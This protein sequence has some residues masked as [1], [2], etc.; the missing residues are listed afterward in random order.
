MW[1]SP[2]YL[3]KYEYAKTNPFLIRFIAFLGVLS[4]I[5]VAIGFLNYL[6][7]NLLYALVF[8]PIIFIFVLNKFLR[9]FIQLFYQKFDPKLH[10]SF[11]KKYWNEHDEPAVD[12]FLPWAG[13]DLEMHEQVVR[14]VSWINYKNK[15]VY[16]LDDI[17]SEEHRLLAEKYGFI[18]LS[19]PNKGQHKKSGNLEYGYNHS[20]GDYVFILDADF[21]PT[22]DSLRDLI[23]YIATDPKIGILQTPQYFEQTN[24][25][26]ERSKIE[27]GGGNIVEDFYKIIMPCR[28]EFGAA[29]CVGTSA[30]YRRDAIKMLNGTPKVHASED[31]ATG[32]LITQY[33]YYVKYL[34]LIVSMGKS[35]DTFQGYF[36]QHLRW[37][38][39]NLVF[40]KYWP[41][42]RL[43]LMARLIYMINPMY[44]I[45]EA[46]AVVL[47]FQFLI[48]IY[49]HSDSLSIMHSLYFLPYIFLSRLVLPQ[50]KSRKN[51]IGT[52]LA[53]LNNSYTYF[54]TYIRMATKG[55]PAWHPSGVKLDGIQGDF[56]SAYNIGAFI[57]S[58]FIVLFIIVLSI[59]HEIFGN[60]NAYIVLGWVF[61]SLFWHVMYLTSVSEYIHPY[62]MA[63]AKSF[64][65]R[66]FVYAKKHTALFLF[67][68]LIGT[69]IFNLAL[70]F[71]NPSTPVYVALG[72]LNEAASPKEDKAIL[73]P[74]A[75]SNF[76]SLKKNEPDIKIASNSP[77]LKTEY[78]FEVKPGKNLTK[79]A[80]DA[81]ASLSG[82]FD[83]PLTE[84][85]IDYAA[86]TVVDEVGSVEKLE[87]GDIV[88]IDSNTIIDSVEKAVIN[89]EF[90]SEEEKLPL[91]NKSEKKVEN[92]IPS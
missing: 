68:I 2:L 81:I 35:P 20:S 83:I 78:A 90:E 31:L 15:N 38:S 16:M 72:Q 12:V 49:F 8:G 64:A 3:N 33:G 70:N 22:S 51:K 10:E 14:G 24:E 58:T 44:Y 66:S 87:P 85:Q 88:S 9:F 55:V 89:I 26:H 76:V 47:A 17:G 29:M 13:E 28:D 80:E 86:A 69:S 74:L 40:A 67:G 34:P 46:A 41:T 42:A 21:I 6:K 60:Y 91:D 65:S 18:Y 19:R 39:G 63:Y 1:R 59:R 57:S 77:I 27:F 32:L 25:V 48:L 92:E 4:V 71:T 75:S 23:P 7:L 5:L 45:S 79:I 54:Y 82:E 56:L 36:K 61:Y 73:T 37:C 30:I 62:R 50:I 84:K 11:V 52:K 43:N 53:A